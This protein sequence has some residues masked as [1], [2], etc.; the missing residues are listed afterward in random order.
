MAEVKNV[1]LDIDKNNGKWEATVGY[2]LTFSAA[3]VGKSHRVTI[4][5][6]AVELLADG[7]NPLASANAPPLYTFA[8]QSG[9]GLAKKFKTITP[10]VAGDQP[11][12]SEK[13]V[14]SLMG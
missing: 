7:D 5:L 4:Q 1:T 12:A 2:T 8:F 10:T 13:R 9:V 3:D 14:L 6:F 11:A